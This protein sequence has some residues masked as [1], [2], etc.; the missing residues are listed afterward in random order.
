LKC[1]LRI[2]VYVESKKKKEW[3]EE[4]VKLIKWQHGFVGDLW[5]RDVLSSGSDIYVLASTSLQEGSVTISLAQE[6]S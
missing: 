2:S 1:T 3:A 6:N 4:G 5:I